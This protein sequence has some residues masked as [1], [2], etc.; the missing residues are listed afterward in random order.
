MKEELIKNI[1]YTNLSTIFS[2]EVLMPLE[3]IETI[4]D[5][6]NDIYGLKKDIEI[7]LEANPSSY[8]GK[9]FLKLKQMNKQVINWYNLIQ[10]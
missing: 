4:I 7:T 2:V 6:C 8:D 10:T 9:K 3:I 1:R 5:T